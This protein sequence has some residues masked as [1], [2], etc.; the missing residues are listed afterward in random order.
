VSVQVF[1]PLRIVRLV[2]G[3]RTLTALFTKLLQTIPSLSNI[4]FLL[5]L[6]LFVLSILGL[7]LYGHIPYDADSNRCLSPPWRDTF[8]PIIIYYLLLFIIHYLL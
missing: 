5:V 7:D 4:A 2:H 3:S 6:L 1:R 8:V